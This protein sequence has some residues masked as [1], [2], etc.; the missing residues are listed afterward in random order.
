[1]SNDN[2]FVYQ[3][4]ITPAVHTL[5]ERLR[6]VY[7]LTYGTYPMIGEQRMVE[8]HLH[9]YVESDSNDSVE[10]IDDRTVELIRTMESS[11]T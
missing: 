3:L 2:E 7:H 11:N 5:L 6:F 4:L 8:C 1:M 10:V 9:C